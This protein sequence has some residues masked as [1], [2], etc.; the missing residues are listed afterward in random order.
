[1]E[2]GEEGGQGGQGGAITQGAGGRGHGHWSGMDWRMSHEA[3]Y[4]SLFTGFEVT[5]MSQFEDI[6]SLSDSEGQNKNTA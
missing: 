4:F 2:G 3:D 5:G 6:G 1:M